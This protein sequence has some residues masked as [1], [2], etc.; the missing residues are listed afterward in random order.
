MKIINVCFTHDGYYKI[1]QV[2]G[3]IHPVIE[4]LFERGMIR[5][6][7][8]FE[9]YDKS[10]IETYTDHLAQENQLGRQID[11]FEDFG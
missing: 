3:D 6:F 2:I 8:A 11:D 7:G 1:A 4:F 9:T 5:W 10:Q